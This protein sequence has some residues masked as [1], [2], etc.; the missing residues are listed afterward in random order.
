MLDLRD[1]PLDQFANA[2]E[3]ADAVVF[4]AGSAAGE[5][6]EIDRIGVRRTLN[7]A[8]KAGIRRYVAVSAIGASTGLSTRGMDAEMQDY[9]RQKRAAGKLIRESGLDWTILEPAEL[10]DGK[11]T[12]RVEISVFSLRE[13]AVARADVAAVAVAVLGEPKSIGRALQITG[14]KTPIAEALKMAVA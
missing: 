14:G 6:S 10:T 9:Y 13:A 12:G 5:S 4:A 7:E 1:S 11:A 8:R 3:G 2:F